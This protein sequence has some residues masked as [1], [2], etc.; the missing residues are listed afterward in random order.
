MLNSHQQVKL[1]EY[2]F[3]KYHIDQLKDMVNYLLE[4]NLVYKDLM[5]KLH[6]YKCCLV[7]KVMYQM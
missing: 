6:N 4:L 7:L 2:H 5:V 3:Q 1:E